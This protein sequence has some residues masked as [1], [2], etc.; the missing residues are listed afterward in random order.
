MLAAVC[1]ACLALQPGCDSKEA[2]LRVIAEV[3][4]FEFVE[5]SGEPIRNEHLKEKIW[6][7]NFFFTGCSIQCVQLSRR[8]AQVQAALQEYEDVRL[9]SFTVDPDGDSPEALRDYAERFKADP[10]RWFF[11]TGNKEKLHRFIQKSFLLPAS[12]NPDAGL[13]PTDDF[14]HSEIFALVDGAGKVRAY[15]DGLDPST[16]AKILKAVKALRAVPQVLEA[17]VQ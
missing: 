13:L 7:A 16:P 6:V 9:V 4:P 3:E 5:K 12:D 15:Y 1:L 10:E 11:V 8:M 17:Q 2:R 14:I